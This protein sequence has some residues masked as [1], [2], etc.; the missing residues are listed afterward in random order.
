MAAPER[1]IV[2]AIDASEQAEHAFTCEYESV[3]TEARI[4]SYDYEVKYAIY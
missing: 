3:F 2:I 1:S 4:R